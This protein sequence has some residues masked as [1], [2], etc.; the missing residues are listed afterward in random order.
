MRYPFEGAEKSILEFEEVLNANGISIESNSDLERVSLLVLE[1]NGKGKKE[2]PHDNKQDIRP[3]FADVAGIHDFTRKVVKHKNH[4]DFSQLIPHLRIL[5][6]ANTTVM[7]SRSL[8]SDDGNNK[9][10]ELYIALLCMDFATNIKLDDPNNS[11]GDNADI[12]FR[13]RNITYAIACKAMHSRNPKTLHDALLKGT[14]QIMS[15]ASERGLVAVNFKNLIDWDEIWPITNKAEVENHNA[16]PLF[17]CFPDV[18]VPNKILEQFGTKAR[19]DLIETLGLDNLRNLETEKSP[20]AFLIFLQALTSIQDGMD[21]PPTILKTMHFV[22]FN[23]VAK[24]DLEVAEKLNEA[25]HD[26]L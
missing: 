23:G 11:K 14:S 9:L 2:I 10:M 6:K 21:C 3:F 26:Q 8:V 13:F 19:T 18:S 16:E 5:N 15:C 12:M 17:G 22:S 1:A 20:A 24:L 7:T 25:M 4:S